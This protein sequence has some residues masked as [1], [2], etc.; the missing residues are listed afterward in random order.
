MNIFTIGFTKKSA[1]KFFGLIKN[2]G[3]KSVIDVRL[4]NISQ[5]SGFAKKDD[6]KYFLN[7]ICGVSYIHEPA[8]APTQ[9][10][11]DEYKKNGGDWHT[12]EARFLDLMQKRRI[13]NRIPVELINSGCL[14]CS[15]DQPH[16]CHRRIVAEYFKNNVNDKLTITHLT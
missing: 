9:Q 14:L 16:Q 3:A 11:L 15:E 6:L 1:Q 13:E 12:Y 2:S 10:M 4:N 5:L 8:L 7:E